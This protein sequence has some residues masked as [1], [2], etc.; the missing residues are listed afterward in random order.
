MTDPLALATRLFDEVF[1]GGDLEVVGE[2]VSPQFVEHQFE[3]PERPARVTGPEGVGRLVRQLRAGA[4]DLR[5]DIEDA[6]VHG[7]TVWLRLRAT[8]TDTGGQL[9]FPATGRRFSITVIDVLRADDGR[10]VEHWGVPDRLGLLQ[11][12]GHVRLPGRSA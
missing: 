6:A 12:L 9:G 4:D 5:Y 3:S 1:N 10:L 11:Q 8:G 2:L 7:D